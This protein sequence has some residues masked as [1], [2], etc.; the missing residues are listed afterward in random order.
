MQAEGIQPDAQGWEKLLQAGQESGMAD[1]LQQLR[2]AQE[3]R[4]KTAQWSPRPPLGTLPA[5]QQQS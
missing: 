1:F 3:Y 2:A 5:G 4:A